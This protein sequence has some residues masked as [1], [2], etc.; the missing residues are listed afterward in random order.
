[1][2]KL[3]FIAAM[4]A[5]FLGLV[6]YYYKNL[7]E[8]QERIKDVYMG[9]NTLLLGRLKKVYDDKLATDLRIQELEERAKEDLAFDWGVDISNS[10]VILELKK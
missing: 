7:A 9:N 10:P 3:F 1:M 6:A 4:T 2:N 5:V 8:E